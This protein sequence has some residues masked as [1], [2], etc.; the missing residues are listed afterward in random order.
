MG[1]IGQLTR[2]DD[3]RVDAPDGRAPVI[4]F[5]EVTHFG[6]AERLYDFGARKTPE[7][8]RDA[9][10]LANI[11][12]NGPGRYVSRNHFLVYPPAMTD[13]GG[14]GVCD[15]N[16]MNG[17]RVDGK[18]IDQGVVEPLANGA[19]VSAGT[20]DEPVEFMFEQLS[21]DAS[22]HHALMVG[23]S[24]WN[25]KG[26]RGDVKDLMVELERR[27]FAGNVRALL[28]KQA[29]ESNIIGII[30]H[31]KAQALDEGSFIFHFAGHA[32]RRGELC[33]NSDRIGSGRLAS[34]DLFT[35]LR[36]FRGKV[37]LILDGCYT[38]SFITHQVPH[39]VSIIGHSGTAKEGPVTENVAENRPIRGYTTRAIIKALQE[40]V[41]RIQIPDLVDKI[42]QDS[43]VKWHQRVVHHKPAR[44]E[45]CFQSMNVAPRD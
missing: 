13:I 42:K 14:F 34:S 1:S 7:A 21:N 18:P 44:T 8:F 26:P 31:I 10:V 4:R 2:T 19:V 16:S 39:N 27:G 37:L 6:R 38:D 11:I 3:A 5:D 29:T 9:K 43:R 32:S 28:E 25:L 36:N 22:I 35:A 15:L 30:D 41:H 45:I 33:I 17:T 20:M 40:S 23:H 12:D 24:G